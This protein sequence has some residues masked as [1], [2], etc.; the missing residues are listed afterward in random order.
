MAPS[1][2]RD[3]PVSLRRLEEEARNIN[4]EMSE[5]FVQEPSIEELESDTLIALKRFNIRVRTLFHL[6]DKEFKDKA[7]CKCDN[8]SNC[9]CKPSTRK[10]YINADTKDH[11][12]GTGL[13]SVKDT[14]SSNAM[15]GDE[16]CELF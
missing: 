16:N 8:S 14:Y 11:G 3:F 4:Q 10:A 7:K 15:R 1:S 12:L 13:Y 5:K 9:K 6:R 2:Q